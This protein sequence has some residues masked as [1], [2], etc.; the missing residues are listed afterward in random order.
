ML[1]WKKDINGYNG[2]WMG[3]YVGFED[4]RPLYRVGRDDDG[5]Y[6]EYLLGANGFDGYESV[7]EAKAA[8]EADY[9]ADTD[10]ILRMF[11]EEDEPL[12]WEDLED[13]HWD[14]VAHKRMEI[15]K[16]GEW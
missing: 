5:W 8:A 12:T 7:E 2:N 13:I 11:D 6:Y 10:S 9:K 3:G 16:F 14:E 1:N 15:A 4:G